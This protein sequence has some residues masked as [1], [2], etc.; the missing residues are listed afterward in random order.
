MTKIVLITA[1]ELEARL[2]QCLGQHQMPDYFL[3]LGDD[4]ASNWLDL[5]ESDAFPVAARLTGLLAQNLA[6]VTRH[7]PGTLDLVSIGVGSGE[8][9]RM[10]LEAMLDRC[11]P[12]YYA[13]DVSSQMVD[14][15]LNAAARVPVKKTGVVALLEDMALLRR[16]WDPPVLLCLLGNSFCNYD[17]QFLL[18]TVY[19]HLGFD[20]LFLFDCHMLPA[21][22]EGGAQ[23]RGE[24]E[25]A[26]RCQANVRFNIGPLVR[27][28]LHPGDCAFQLDLLPMQTCVGTVYRTV[29][30]VRILKET[31]LSC[32]TGAVRLA[33]GDVIHLGFTYKYT[34]PHI[35]TSL[36]SHGFQTVELLLSRDGENLLALVRKRSV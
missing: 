14:K 7:L 17:P 31:T 16:L 23:K 13:V 22:A 8:K 21:A 34:L 36:E 5:S 20:D 28:G 32:G 29:K 30:S 2:Q 25:A 3:Y 19:R 10:L 35:E 15:A 11:V 6:S 27:R 4:G 33:A 12:T 26:Y 18:E 24:V 9:E 1:D